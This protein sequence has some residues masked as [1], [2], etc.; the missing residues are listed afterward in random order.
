MEERDRKGTGGRHP[1]SFSI[2][3]SVP[4]QKLGIWYL[5]G[6]MGE[7]EG[8]HR[9]QQIGYVGDLITS[10]VG[11]SLKPP[12]N[13]NQS[14]ETTMKPQYGQLYHHSIQSVCLAYNL[15]ACYGD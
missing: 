10:N 6:K 3:S 7:M 1:W 11:H 14:C 9:Y 4:I 5:H 13:T 12:T 2:R 15:F 8:I